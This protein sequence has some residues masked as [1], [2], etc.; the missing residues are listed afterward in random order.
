MFG[1]LLNSGV[2]GLKEMIVRQLDRLITNNDDTGNDRQ[3]EEPKPTAVLTADLVF[4]LYLSPPI[5]IGKRGF[6]QFRDNLR[7]SNG[8][9]RTVTTTS[10]TAAASIA[11]AKMRVFLQRAR[12]GY[13]D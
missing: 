5:Q 9:L 7:I 11:P 12:L 10:I 8:Y 3:V 1:E 6:S 13:F 4:V 2:S